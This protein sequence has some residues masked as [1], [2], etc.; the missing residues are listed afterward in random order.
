[1]TLM[2][3][4]FYLRLPPWSSSSSPRTAARKAWPNIWDSNKCANGCQGICYT[5]VHSYKL[6]A[7]DKPLNNSIQAYV[8]LQTSNP[9]GDTRKNLQNQYLSIVRILIYEKVKRIH[10]TTHHYFPYTWNGA[11]GNMLT[12]M[13]AFQLYG[14]S[15]IM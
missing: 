2:N 13:D 8:L 12:I 14:I 11:P 9:E 3:R 1:M 7:R 4:F 10:N 5:I 15:V 6:L